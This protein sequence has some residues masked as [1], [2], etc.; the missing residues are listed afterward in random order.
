MTTS[1][2]TPDPD[3]DEIVAAVLAAIRSLDPAKQHEVEAALRADLQA[4]DLIRDSRP[5]RERSAIAALVQAASLADDA[6]LSLERYRALRSKHTNR[7]WPDDRSIRR[8][9]GV[10]S[11]NDALRRA[12]LDVTPDGD[13]IIRQLGPAYTADEL[14]AAVLACA[15]DIGVPPSFDAYVAWARNPQVRRRPGRRPMSQSPFTRAGGFRRVLECA[16][17]IRCDSDDAWKGSG[18]IIRTAGYVITDGQLQSALAEVTERLGHAPRVSEYIE[19]RQRIFDETAAAGHPRA[20]P[21]YNTFHRRFGTLE[22]HE[23]LAHFGFELGD[24]YSGKPGGAKG[25][26]GPRI[27]EEQMLSILREAAESVKGKLTANDY[28]RWRRIQQKLDIAA[29]RLRRLPDYTTYW[30]YFGSWDEALAK[31]FPDAA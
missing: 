18:A 20:L 29:G 15:A 3:G 4:D 25:P 1:T 30:S 17:L 19:L 11:W 12:R 24:R 23:I 31:A 27:P 8:W 2:I 5:A 6:T 7:G 16:G 10:S 21:S 22:W 28:K 9:L 14:T 13:A 26:T